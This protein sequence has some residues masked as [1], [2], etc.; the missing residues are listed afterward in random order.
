[1]GYAKL[2]LKGL[3]YIIIISLYKYLKESVKFWQLELKS[4]NYHTISR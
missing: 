2:F 1:M 3:Q 4:F